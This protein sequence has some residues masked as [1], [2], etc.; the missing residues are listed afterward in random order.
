MDDLTFRKAVYAEPFTTDP[1]VLDAAAQD[2]KKQAFWK[3]IKAMEN[4]LKAAMQIPVPE[5]LAEK[6]I[7]RQSLSE[8]NSHS[9]KRPWYLALAASVV[10]ASVLTI[11]MLNTGNNKLTNDVFAHMS[12]VDVEIMKGI[13]V[14][15]NTIN[16]KLASFNGQVN[17]DLGEV[18]SANYCYLD[19]IKSLH[20]IIRGENGLTSLFVVPD[21]ITESLSDTFNNATY[22]GVSF[23]LNSAKVIVVGE[24]KA[25]VQLLE[26]RAKQ[27]MSF[28]A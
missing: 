13:P 4:E 26:K 1:A 28:T 6:L 17:G 22:E 12:H 10:F 20:L 8:H 11:G 21:S 18:V 14:G 15:P 7:L 23:L 5:N 9:Q 19:K 24:N 27:A 25:D 3:G 2:P 16:D